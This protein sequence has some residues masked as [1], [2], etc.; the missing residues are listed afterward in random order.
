LHELFF[1]DGVFLEVMFFFIFGKPFGK[2][3]V[4]FKSEASV[5][6]FDDLLFGG[7]PEHFFGD[8]KGLS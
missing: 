2:F 7:V 4:V 3:I 6:V 5:G 1:G 8:G